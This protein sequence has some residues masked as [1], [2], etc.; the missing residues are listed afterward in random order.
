MN[1]RSPRQVFNYHLK[2]HLGNVRIVLQPGGLYGQLVQSNDY[3]PFGMAYTRYGVTL[4]DGNI[5]AVAIAY[6]SRHGIK[7]SPTYTKDNRY[8][9]NGKEEQPMPGK[10]LDYGARFYDAQLGR[11]H[12]VDP[13]SEKGRRWSPYTYALDNPI[14]FI[15]PDGMWADGYTVDNEGKVNRVDDTGGDDYDVLYTK[16]DYEEAKKTG[17]INKDGNPEPENQ[18]KLRDTS[19]LPQLENRSN[20]FEFKALGYIYIANVA[21]ANNRN[22]AYNLFKFVAE[23]TKV[24]WNYQRYTDGTLSVVTANENST[25]A[26]GIG[27]SSNSGK[28][29]AADIHSHPGKTESDL[30]PS[31]YDYRAANTLHKQ[32]Q[33]VKVQLYMPKSPNPKTR[34]LDL[35][36]NKWINY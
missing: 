4:W 7:E 9:Y 16:Q 23:N 29:V 26:G 20:T 15:D 14:R 1:L 17:E 33:N 12:S 3:F 18:V 2:D 35:V 10:W 8:L 21:N 28:T 24:E 32:N 27:H 30:R 31:S 36:N 13:L 34:W 19:I 6:D 22:D 5:Q 25:V 11:W